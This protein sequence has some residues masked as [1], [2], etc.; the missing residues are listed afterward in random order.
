MGRRTRGSVVIFA[1]ATAW[2]FVS[3]L[4]REVPL[5]ALTLVFWRVLLGVLAVGVVMLARGRRAVFRPP[6][7]A[8]AALGLILGVHWICYFAAI[9]HTSVA[10]ANLITY[11]NPIVIA[12]LAPALLGERIRR[13]TV[14]ALAASV[15]GIVL[16]AA[17]G[18]SSGSGAVRPA[19]LV[20]ASLAA[21]SYAAM[22]LGM[23]RWSGRE[24]PV[25]VVFW[26]TA[27]AALA[28][29][30]AAIPTLHH[31]LDLRQWG[32]LVLLGFV[33]TGVSGL[34][35]VRAIRWV[36]A[37]SV[38]I[39]AYMEPVSAALLAALLIGEQLTWSIAV[40]GAIIVAA[41]VAV[42]RL[43]EPDEAIAPTGPVPPRMARART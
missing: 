10:S 39:L 43:Q 41:G 20:L 23:K 12:A 38:G 9:Q 33:L 26:Q 6:G 42:I 16:I 28:L 19:G 7:W 36:P 27:V 13:V 15:V 17:F 37:T 31:S 29:L 18:P 21:V 1:L 34:I 11:A 40:G 8:T 30:P 2:G 14:L 25:R 32:Y 3:V 4:V 5:P 35:F 24:D 22:I